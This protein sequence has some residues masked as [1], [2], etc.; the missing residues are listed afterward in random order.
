MFQ[1]AFARPPL[2]DESARWRQ[3]VDDLARLHGAAPEETL[4]SIPVWKDIAHAIF[5]T[6]EFI[7]VR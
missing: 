4:V 1:T 5:N 2:A 6:K 3:G 7:Y